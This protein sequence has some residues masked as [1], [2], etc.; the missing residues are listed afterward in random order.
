MSS[1]VWLFLFDNGNNTRNPLTFIQGL[2]QKADVYYQ[3]GEFEYALIYY[4]R[5]SKIR[6]EIQAFRLGVQKSQEAI[7]NCIGGKCR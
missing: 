3:M 1:N 2:L 6:A 7:D 4:H 5:G